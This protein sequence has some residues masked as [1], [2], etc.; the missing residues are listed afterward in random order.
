MARLL[1]YKDANE[2]SPSSEAEKSFDSHEIS[3]I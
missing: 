1:A 2:S 3:R